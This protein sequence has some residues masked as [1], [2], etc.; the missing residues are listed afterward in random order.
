[1]KKALISALSLGILGSFAFSSGAS[2]DS[3]PVPADRENF[4][5]AKETAVSVMSDDRSL[6]VYPISGRSV[7]GKNSAGVMAFGD[8]TAGRPIQIISVANFFYKNGSLATT[9]SSDTQ[10]GTAYANAQ[11]AYGYYY[12][13]GSYRSESVHKFYNNGQDSVLYTQDTDF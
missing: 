1:M 7:L 9:P 6:F 11:S 8:S 3:I 10:Y 2:A 5:N 4:K 13:S 12:T